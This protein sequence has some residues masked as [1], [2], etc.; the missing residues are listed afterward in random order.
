[1]KNRDSHIIDDLILE[2]ERVGGISGGGG[3]CEHKA[4]LTKTV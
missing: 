3:I 1:M 4:A 2:R